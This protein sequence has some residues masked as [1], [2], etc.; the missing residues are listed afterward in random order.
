MESQEEFNKNRIIQIISKLLT[1]E[2]FILQYTD[3]I[4]QKQLG[5]VINILVKTM[6]KL[7]DNLLLHFSGKVGFIIIYSFLCFKQTRRIKLVKLKKILNLNLH[8]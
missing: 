1:S 5:I 6:L 3:R 8:H 2:R 7:I 4:K